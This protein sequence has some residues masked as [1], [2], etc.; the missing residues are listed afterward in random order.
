M[1]F[2]YSSDIHGDNAKYSKLI[3]LCEKDNV[4]CLVI[5]G[6][7]YL[8]RPDKEKVQPGYIT[9]D[10][11]SFYATLAKKGIECICINGNEDL[12]QFNELHK[13]V[14]SKYPNVHYIDNGM[15]V[16]GDVCFIGMGETLDGPGKIKNR[17]VTE[18]DYPMQKQFHDECIV[19]QCTRSLTVDEYRIYREKYLPKMEDVLEKL[20]KNNTEYKTIYV[21]HHPPHGVGLDVCPDGFCAGSKAI[22]E[23]LLNS[24]AYMSLHGHI[25]ESYKNSGIWK[26]KFNDCISIQAGQTNL[27]DKILVY[28]VIDTDKD[29]VERYEVEV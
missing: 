20:P 9:Q 22:N 8:N 1:K 5:G 28:C 21:M 7:L 12:E 23:F 2:I 29:F 24:N 26:V 3:D 6:D 10:L 19:E 14:Y 27:H 15:V 13:S 16:Q 4:N 18:K 11:D 17:M 25:H